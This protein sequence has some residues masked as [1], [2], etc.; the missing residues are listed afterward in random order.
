MDVF[1]YINLNKYD[2]LDDRSDRFTAWIV[3]F[4]TAFVVITICSKSSFLYAFNLWDDANSYF[5][6]GKC[7]F[8]G[9]VPYK[10]LFDQKGI[11][12][13]TIYGLASL[14]SST[15]FLGV[16]IFEVI[17]ATF[18]C[19]GLLRI[20]QLYLRSD[21]VPYFMMPFTALS[22]YTAK[23][24]YW[25]G[26]AE[27]FLFP[28]IVWG[29]YLSLR[30]F[31]ETYPDTMPYR[32]VLL[33]GVLAG[34]VFHIKF[35]SLGFFFAWMA[36][37]FFGDIIGS[38]VR[39]LK[40]AIISCF[41][42]L[43]GMAIT[44]IPGI[45]YFGVNS[46]I[47]DWYRVYIYKNVFEYSKSMTIGQRL[48]K[49]WDI[50]TDHFFDN[51]F[52]YLTIFVGAL[53]FT[54][55]LISYLIREDRYKLVKRDIVLL[56]LKIIE[57]VNIAM[58]MLFLILVIFI[59]GV[60]ITYYPFP[61][62]AF[63]VFC[64]VAV[65]YVIEGLYKYLSREEFGDL[66]STFG[67]VSIFLAL[68]ITGVYA[69][70]ISPNVP[71]MKLKKD[72]IWLFKFRDYVLESGIENP[73][74]MNEYGFDA[75]L[76]TVTNT[77]PICYYYQTQTLNI[78]EVIEWQKSYTRSGQADF[79]L[80]IDRPAEAV[81]DYELVLQEDFVTHDTNTTYFLYQKKSE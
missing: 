39:A 47:D 20:I 7:M 32:T 9:Y 56:P 45:V 44:F 19:V 42:F 55:A 12:L 34:C 64:S 11:F 4:V 18:V 46:A 2:R 35:N 30:H 70:F 8:R 63:A 76:Y 69:Y 25:G 15:T 16:Y 26:S 40:K 67:F 28:F 52:V 77:M 1:S 24:F 41:V 68:L 80:S 3:G 49:I 27:E 33:G 79:V 65:G 59:G 62:N 73:G 54:V 36:M 58:L 38:G 31:R 22:I 71:A 10:N 75:G 66:A 17:A 53:Y 60:S 5:T 51:K 50:M 23:C 48:Y 29:L 81:D 78:E 72:D 14:I 61:I 13:Y 21:V 57:Y 74:I 43:L 37:V 6:M